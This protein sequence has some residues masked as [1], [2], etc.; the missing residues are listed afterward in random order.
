MVGRGKKRVGN[1]A[2]VIGRT[3]L[4]VAATAILWVL[5]VFFVSSGRGQGTTVS[6]RNRGAS[7]SLPHGVGLGLTALA[8]VAMIAALAV[9]S[10]VMFVGRGREDPEHRRVHEW[11]RLP[12]WQQ[13]AWVIA[14]IVLV[15][16]LLAGLVYVRHSITSRTP[17]STSAHT[18]QLPPSAGRAIGTA[19]PANLSWVVLFGVAVALLFLAAAIGVAVARRR[20]S[21]ATPDASN[22]VPDAFA[23]GLEAGARDLAGI[24][25][26]R[27]AVIACYARMEGALAAVGL[28]RRPHE[29]PFELLARV[30]ER[31]KVAEPHA[32]RLTTHF[33]RAMF[34]PR[35]VDE[36][37]RQEALEALHAVQADL[38]SKPRARQ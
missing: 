6:A 18:G 30:L 23:Q 14:A 15:T 22:P 28:P 11:P 9:L 25:D 35:S 2:R 27:R 19:N 32:E 29:T 12:W 13:A 33:E 20:A 1:G 10:W 37:T 38:G 7:A 26:P 5:A 21:R 4:L 31:W 34:S 36:P 3:P 8:L 16:G 17:S 24:A